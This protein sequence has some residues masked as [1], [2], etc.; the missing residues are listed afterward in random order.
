[1][2]RIKKFSFYPIMIILC[3]SFILSVSKAE[4][5]DEASD[6][7]VKPGESF[8]YNYKTYQSTNE[9]VNMDC[10]STLTISIIDIASN[11][12]LSYRQVIGKTTC[13][14]GPEQHGSEYNSSTQY[15]VSGL[16]GYA[17]M[18]LP[19]LNSTNWSMY[20]EPTLNM[21]EEMET[22][23]N[24]SGTNLFFLVSSAV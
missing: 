22:N 17:I 18:N 14:V 24:F 2:I 3:F 11:G 12:T 19:T 10:T 20:F 5:A 13:T 9:T 6:W 15:G 7:G 1:M 4:M 21:I 16:M 23:G 8:K